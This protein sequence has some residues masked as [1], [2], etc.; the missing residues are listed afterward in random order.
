[1]T[2][3]LYLLQRLTAA[4]MVPLIAGHLATIIYATHNGVSAADI[5]GRTRGSLGWAV[6]Y[7]LFVVLAA[8]HASIGVRSVAGDWTALRGL[9]LTLLTWGFGLILLLLGAR[10]IYAVIAA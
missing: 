5:L 9:A 4:L 7:G 1:V 8:V 6:F 3:R 2:L 10:G